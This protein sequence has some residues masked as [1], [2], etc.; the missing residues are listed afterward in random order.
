MSVVV[1]ATI[2][3]L[4]EHRAEV[5]AV[6]AET[7]ARVHAEDAGCELYALHEGEDRLVMVEKWASAED[8]AAH[9]KGSA[10]AEMNGRLAGK[11]AGRPD[12]QVLT[13]HPAGTDSQG[14]I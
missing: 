6:F 9:S 4:P 5:I 2:H 12:V 10:L 14:A 1:V 7:I 8:L 11:V 3:P 13:A